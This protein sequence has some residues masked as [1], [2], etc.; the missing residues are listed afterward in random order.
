MK[1]LGLDFYWDNFG[2]ETPSG[3]A[4]IFFPFPNMRRYEEIVITSTKKE[5]GKIKHKSKLKYRFKSHRDPLS[6]GLAREVS[7]KQLCENNWGF[8]Q[9][10]NIGEKVTSQE[11][12]F[13]KY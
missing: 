2:I 7:A 12:L 6:V 5:S 11:Y 9:D 8:L 1:F 10:K 4:M 13:S 3:E